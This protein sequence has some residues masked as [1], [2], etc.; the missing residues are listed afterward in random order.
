MFGTEFLA[1]IP[2]HMHT[3]KHTNI[4]DN[5][6]CSK[7]EILELFLAEV[8]KMKKAGRCS[9]YLSFFFCDLL[10][11]KL[12][13]KCYRM[14]IPLLRKPYHGRIWTNASKS[15]CK[16]IRIYMEIRCN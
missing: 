4:S 15:I 8:G 11:D 12:S 9:E 5:Y 10:P 6:S 2:T 7:G 1:N 16:Y 14:K 3:H 13:K